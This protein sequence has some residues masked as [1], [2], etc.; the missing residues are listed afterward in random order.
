MG[1]P[2]LVLVEKPERALNQSATAAKAPIASTG[3]L[4][5]TV[6]TTAT[7]ATIA[8]TILPYNYRPT[9][10]CQINHVCDRIRFAWHFL[11]RYYRSTTAVN[12]KRS[13]SIFVDVQGIIVARYSP[14]GGRQD[15]RAQS[16]RFEFFLL[17][18]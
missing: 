18:F 12:S 8:R 7:T 16:V 9:R 11:S 13:K 6:T 4:Y 14:M 5:M 10:I 17:H 15:E 3:P 2:T 1:Q